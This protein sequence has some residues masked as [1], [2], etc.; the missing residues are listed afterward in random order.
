MAL[1]ARLVLP[2][3]D[4]EARQLLHTAAA[5]LAAAIAVIMGLLI[6]VL[7]VGYTWSRA[8]LR[9]GGTPELFAECTA[10]CCSS[11]LMWLCSHK[12]ILVVLATSDQS[13]QQL[14]DVVRYC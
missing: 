13:C 9:V 4:W 10:G 1:K 11:A 7:C 6:Q 12:V 3:V 8:G 2:A 14:M 5:K